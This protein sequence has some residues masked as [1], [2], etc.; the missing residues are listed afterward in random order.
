MNDEQRER[1]AAV[2]RAFV[3]PATPH[4]ATVVLREYDPEWPLLYEREEKRIRG[5]L[6]D[7]VIR[8]EHVGSTSIPGM[9]AK[10]RI[11]MV[12]GVRDSAQ[13]DEY[14]PDME[15]LG[16]VLTIRE[17]DWYEHRLFKG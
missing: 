8:L 4:N 6:G 10:P 5:A 16:Y 3:K 13:E 17:P 7:R 1:D 11:D 9:A 2:Q 15:A 12:L 14:V